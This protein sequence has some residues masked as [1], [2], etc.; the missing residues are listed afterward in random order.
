VSLDKKTWIDHFARFQK[1]SSVTSEGVRGF[2]NFISSAEMDEDAN[3]R[4]GSFVSL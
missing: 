3:F 4:V 2:M 1:N